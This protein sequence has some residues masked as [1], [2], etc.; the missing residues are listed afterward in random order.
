VIDEK[1]FFLT[2]AEAMKILKL[3]K[4]TFYRYVALSIIPSVKVGSQLRFRCDDI[5]NFGQKSA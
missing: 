2:A 4:S 5:I 3:K 1:E